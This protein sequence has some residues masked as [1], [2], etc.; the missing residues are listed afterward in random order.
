MDAFISA[1]CFS[2]DIFIWVTLV[3]RIII[4]VGIKKNKNAL[5]HERIK[6]KSS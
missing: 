2:A 1:G 5:L 3:Q 6:R 4:K